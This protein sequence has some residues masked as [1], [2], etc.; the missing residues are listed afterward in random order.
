MFSMFSEKKCMRRLIHSLSSRAESPIEGISCTQP[1]KSK[2][3]ESISSHYT[4]LTLPH[5]H[6]VYVKFSENFHLLRIHMVR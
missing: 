1:D 6:P 4:T 2:D 3:R 5:T